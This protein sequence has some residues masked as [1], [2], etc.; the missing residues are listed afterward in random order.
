MLLE[1]RNIYH[2]YAYNTLFKKI[3]KQILN[4]INLNIDY[5][6]NTA[7]I[8]PSGCGKSTL[9]RII[10]QIQKP[11]SGDI[12]LNGIKVETKTLMQKRN[13]YKQ[14]Q[15]LFQDPIS[16]LNPRLNIFQSLQEP[17]I[18]LFAIKNTQEQLQMILPFLD[19]LD[20]PK[21]ILYYYPT[22]LSGGQAQ[23]ICI[24]RM[25]LVQPKFALLDEI[26]SGLDYATQKKVLDLLVSLQC[27]NSSSFLF[28]T[29]DISLAQEFCQNIILMQDGKIIEIITNQE[30]FTSQLGNELINGYN[31]VL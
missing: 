18:N 23:R 30:N 7:L 24:I 8:G 9:A 22:M 14:V 1:V 13:F 19:S 2:H 15:I 28:I 10:A 21:Q 4:N 3:Q 25:L 11:T 26:T 5:A 16:S 27:K 20:L 12:L 29:H 31:H 6:Q 17:L